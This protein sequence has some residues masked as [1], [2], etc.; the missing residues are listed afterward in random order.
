MLIVIQNVESDTSDNNSGL[1]ATLD[2]NYD[3]SDNK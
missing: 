3:I 2:I 1:V